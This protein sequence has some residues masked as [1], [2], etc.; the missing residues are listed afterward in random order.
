MVHVCD[1]VGYLQFFIILQVTDNSELSIVHVSIE[2]C[3]APLIAGPAW[4]LCLNSINY[5]DAFMAR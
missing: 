5:M 1:Q 4:R 2:A 3:P